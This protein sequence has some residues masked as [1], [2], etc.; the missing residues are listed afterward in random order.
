MAEQSNTPTNIDLK[1]DESLTIDWADGTRSVFPIAYLRKMSPSAEMRELRK[2]M[3]TN[4][5]TILPDGMGSSSTIAATGAESVGNYA[6]KVLFSDGHDT[7]LYTWSYLREIDP[8]NQD[9][10]MTKSD[11]GPSHNNPLGLPGNR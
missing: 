5:L 10:G 8:A 1:K 6:I 4:P 9:G 7:G 2:E 3:N 11:Q